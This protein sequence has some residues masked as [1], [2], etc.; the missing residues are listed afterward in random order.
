M[1]Q[2]AAPTGISAKPAS[3]RKGG[4]EQHEIKTEMERVREASVR[5]DRYT[6]WREGSQR[7]QKG[8]K[9]GGRE[10]RVGERQ[11]GSNLML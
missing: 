4:K 10:L 9:E 3:A 5:L 8:G 2:T 1:T 6:V 11:R 7:E